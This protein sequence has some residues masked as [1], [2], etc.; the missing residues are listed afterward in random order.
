MR[1]SIQTATLI[2]ALSSSLAGLTADTLVDG[3]VA[4]EWG[5]FVSAKDIWVNCRAVRSVMRDTPRPSDY[6]TE[7]D[8]KTEFDHPYAT[9]SDDQL[10]QIA[11][12]DW[13]AAYLLAY[14]LLIQ[15][16]SGIPTVEDL[17][18]GLSYAMNAL[19]HTGEKQVFDLMISGRH[20]ENWGVWATLNGIPNDRQI[21]EKEEEYIWYK[22]GHNLGF[23]K[24]DDYQWTRL[25]VVMHRYESYF[26]VGE[27]NVRAA[28]I[29]D[30]VATRRSM[31][32]GE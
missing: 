14:R 22:A 23:I 8:L 24:D 32:A 12:H 30:Y 7:C 1:R 9:F 25:L 21:H 15:P 20:F 4:R 18:S 31:S 26:N 5:D 3:A 19:V 13:E 11:G 6:V 28:E 10:E 29:S 27:L 17:E 16:D 2:V